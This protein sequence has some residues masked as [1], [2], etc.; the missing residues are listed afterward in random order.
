MYTPWKLNRLIEFLKKK[1]PDFKELH[2]GGRYG[3]E[4]N[5]KK[6]EEFGITHI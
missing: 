1:T 3:S 5:D 4:D 6:Y 2:T